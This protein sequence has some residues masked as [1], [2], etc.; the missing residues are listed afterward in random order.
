MDYKVHVAF[1][2][3]VNC[4]HSYRGD[5][6]DKQGFGGDIRIIR[7]IIKVL[8]EFNEKGIPAKGTWDFENAYS[9][10]DILPK[11]APDILE[12]IKV[13]CE[14]Y[15]DENI[16]MGYNNGAL[17]AMN[18]EELAASINLAITNEKGSGLKDV[19]GGY[20]PVV[21]PQEVMFTP[22]QVSTYNKL[23]IKALCLYYSCVPFDAFRTFIPQLSD[24]YAFNP[25][26]YVYKGEK[27]TIMPTYNN[28]DIIDAGSLRYLC[29][30]LHKQQLEGKINHD[31]LIFVNMDADA[32]FW[33]S[34]LPKALSFVPNGD[35]IHGLVKEVADLDYVEYDTVGNYL[36]THEPLCD[37]EFTED[38]ADGGFSG[39][40]SWAE[41]PFNAQIWTRLERARAY[42]KLYNKDSEAPSFDDRIML[43]S[44]THFGLASPVLN[45]Q[46]EKKALEFSENAVNAELNAQKKEK[47]FTLKNISK[48][49]LTSVEL[50][51][52][53]GYLNSISEFEIKGKNVKSF[54]ADAIDFYESGCVK[55]VFAIIKF[56]A[57]NKTE[58]LEFSN[59]GK[60]DKKAKDLELN[61]QSL[62]IKMCKHG[63]ILSV[64]YKDSFIGSKNFL[65]SYI[66]YNNTKYHFENKSIESLSLAGEGEGYIVK[67]E[68]N[69]PTQI[70][71]GSYEFKFFTFKE[72]DCVFVDTH[73]K[74]PYTKE[75]TEISTESTALGRKSDVK[76]IEAVPF[77]ITPTL[78]NNISVVKKNYEED[79][80]SYK[81]GDFAKV[82][83]EN[84]DIDSFNHHLTNGMIAV[85]NE[86]NGLLIANAKQV[87]NSMANCPMRLRTENNKQTI[88]LNPFGTY[89]GKQREYPTRSNHC[90][91]DSFTVVTPQSRSIAPAYNGVEQWTSLAIVGFDGLYP[92]ENT[93]NFVNGFSEGSAAVDGEDK[94]VTSFKEDNIN[95]KAIQE[96]KITDDDLKPVIISGGDATN[97]LNMGKIALRV[98]KNLASAKIKGMK[99]N[100]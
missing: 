59:K 96:N 15:G 57:I 99:A 82:I 37:V 45:V 34:V 22:S 44:T 48:S 73:V 40:V 46:R 5:T 32:I 31:V 80:S 52:E 89:Y 33:E 43:L 98:A 56:K 14:K 85:S 50:K 12:D 28:S 75:E 60:Y 24:E 27:L 53:D 55:A 7:Q 100:K 4:Y 68:I 69:L 6:N 86:K 95:F 62:R 74:Y 41:K 21:R 58:K 87:M 13:R 11:Y 10:E 3:H 19:F 2:F 8:N 16:I 97:L 23:G 54:V 76:W 94:T 70:E 81:V 30:D 1:G 84:K 20:E 26:N 67:G 35:G 66:N 71:G 63:N 65:E 25:V 49:D 42:A 61:T 72:A 83:P 29:Y 88:T 17:S 18:E 92:D 91:Q 47:Q 90:A 78:Q 79:I 39:Y 93:M 36:K 38:T 51:I 64:K 9:I 77:S